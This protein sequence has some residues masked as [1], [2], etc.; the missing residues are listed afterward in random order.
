VHEIV[1][2]PDEELLMEGEISKFKPGIEKNF[3]TRW[4]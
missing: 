1:I 2:D 3:I 4:I